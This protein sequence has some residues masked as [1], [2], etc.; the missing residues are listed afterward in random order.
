[1]LTTAH[2]YHH[3]THYHHHEPHH[4]GPHH[5]GLHLEGSD[6]ISG[7]TKLTLAAVGIGLAS[8]PVLGP[9]LLGGAAVSGAAMLVRRAL[10]K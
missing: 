1:M 8:G 7:Q 3:P 9:I 2:H 4:H 5:H 10:S 6:D